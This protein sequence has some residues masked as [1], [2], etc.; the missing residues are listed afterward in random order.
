MELESVNPFKEFENQQRFT[1]LSLDIND[2]VPF[3]ILISK[4]KSSIFDNFNDDSILRSIMCLFNCNRLLNQDDSRIK[5]CLD[6]LKKIVTNLTTD[7][8]TELEK[9]KRVRRSKIEQKV[10]SLDG[11]LDFL[12]AIGFSIDS[13]DNDWLV[14][15]ELSS[16]EELKTKMSYIL[17]LLSSPQVLPIEFDHQLK[18]MR[19]DD[20]KSAE[21][22]D[23]LQLTSAD[24]KQYY[25][26]LERTREVQEMFVSKDTKAK[27]LGCKTNHKP[28]FAQ[29]RFKYP[30]D[31]GM[32]I[33]QAN[34]YSTD[35]LSD[36]KSWFVANM[37]DEFPCN[38]LDFKIGPELLSNESHSKSL[39]ELQLAPAATLFVIAK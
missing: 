34:F 17:D 22:D 21:E 10:L 29:L 24:V 1:C 7:D 14:Y 20:L 13:N 39:F 12:F 4:I 19:P 5:A 16:P 15:S 26:H 9:F 2:P 25:S 30:T 33:S 31:N 32:K 8:P 36:I 37:I 6:I 35:K 28:I 38:D 27:L 3:D 11:A 18:H 23:A